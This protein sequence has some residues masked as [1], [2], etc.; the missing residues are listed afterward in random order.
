MQMREG[1]AERQARLTK[2][3]SEADI[4]TREH[5]S[6]H[7]HEIGV[8]AG[9]SKRIHFAQRCLKQPLTAEEMLE[10]MPLNELIALAD[11]LERQALPLS[12]S[13]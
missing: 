3:I 9:E 11:Q 6:K 4:A 10:K 13:S 12:E 2:R 1:E 8:A 5:M 7:A